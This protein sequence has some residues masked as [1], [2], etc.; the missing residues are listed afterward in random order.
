M[1]CK[2]GH[3]FFSLNIPGRKMWDSASAPVP[4]NYTLLNT[5]VPL[6][7]DIDLVLSQDRAS[8]HV[9]A[10][11]L[12][13][14]LNVPVV[15]LQHTLPPPGISRANLY[16]LQSRRGILDVFVSEYSQECW[17]SKD[18]AT[19]HT[20]MTGIDTEVFKPLDLEKDG[21][22]LTV[23][24]QFAKRGAE[25]GFNE[26]VQ[27]VGFPEPV[28]SVKII[29]DTPGLSKVA[30][31]TEE[32]VRQYNMSTLYLN[33]TIVS[34]LPTVII[35]AMACGLPIVTTNTCLIPDTLVE[36]GVNGL[37]SKHN[38]PM[39]LRYLC[40][41]L[42]DDPALAAK[43]G[44]ASREKVEKEFTV[45]RFASKWDEIFTEAA[46]IRTM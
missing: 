29:G 45:D 17:G 42:L 20:N 1:M 34:T 2:C 26:W 44:Q 18:S 21:T 10:T 3:N 22:V 27:A 33:T 32:L 38:D 39:E 37:V 4:E 5:N 11:K 23:A 24:N 31:S 16:E 43:M 12:A 15:N 28:F 19:A 46:N 40:Q 35:E 41:T 6:Y 9:G 8:H 25:L 30:P 14:S 13:E 36:H 7:L